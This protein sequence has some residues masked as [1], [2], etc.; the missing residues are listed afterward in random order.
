MTAPAQNPPFNFFQ[1][2]QGHGELDFA[3]AQLLDLLGR[4]PLAFLDSGSSKC[5]EDDSDGMFG[6]SRFSEN[7]ETL[8][9]IPP[10]RKIDRSPESALTY[11][12]V[13]NSRQG[14]CAEASTI[15][16]EGKQIPEIFDATQMV[17]LH[18]TMLIISRARFFVL[19][20]YFQ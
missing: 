19:E 17:R 14:K 6:F 8:L 20:P 1:V 18:V 7:P 15:Q 10:D 13:A 16:I 5:V 12:N 9:E 3:I 11:P 2:S 4:M